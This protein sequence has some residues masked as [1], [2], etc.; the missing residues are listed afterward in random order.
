ML[1]LIDNYDSF[2]FNLY[3]YLS[4]LGEDDI[5]VVRNDK[6]TVQQLDEM[7]PD[8]VVVSPGPS[9]PRNA[10][11]S[12]DAIKH[13]AD[14][15]PVLGVCLGMQCMAEAFGGTVAHAGELRHGKTSDIKH[16]GKG[17]FS[18]LP[19]PFEAVRYHSLA[20]QPDAVPQ[21]FDVT[22]RADSDLQVIMGIRHKRLPMEGVQ[23]HP[24]SIVTK[25]GKD[26]LA[27]FLKM[28]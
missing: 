1:L 12:I 27:N 24:E 7:Q 25:P 8:K 18:G 14:K 13:F 21:D 28:G 11:I 22:A 15:A 5:Q 17:V 19:N 20:V 9:H 2:T 3:Q 6:A 26:L 16:D 4:E 23:F 10:G